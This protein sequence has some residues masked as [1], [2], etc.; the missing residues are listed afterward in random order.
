MSSDD[1]NDDDSLRRQYGIGD[2]PR[3]ATP[4]MYAEDE[5][6][7]VRASA[8]A[9][10]VQLLDGLAQPRRRQVVDSVSDFV[11]A[12][13]AQV[14]DQG[15]HGAMLELFLVEHFM[16]DAD[17][18]RDALEAWEFFDFV[19]EYVLIEHGVGDGDFILNHPNTIGY[20]DDLLRGR[21]PTIRIE[22]ASSSSSS[23]SSTRV[24]STRNDAAS[25]VPPPKWS[26]WLWW[27]PPSAVAAAIVYFQFVS[28]DRFP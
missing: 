27:V 11:E 20:R 8:R 16:T 3:G 23:T 28:V 26:P 25:V 12:V 6:R 17:F 15:A 1:D 14:T 10:L 19:E 22:S 7:R 5:F 9:S 18:V 13:S 24:H 21:E 2:L 4:T